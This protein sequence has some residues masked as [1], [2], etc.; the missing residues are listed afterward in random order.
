MAIVTMVSHFRFKM[1]LDLTTQERKSEARRQLCPRPPAAAEAICVPALFVPE[2]RPQA[3]IIRV[4]AVEPA[5]PSQL[6]RRERDRGDHDERA[7]AAADH[8]KDRAE[9]RRDASRFETPELVRCADE[10]SVD[11]RNPATHL[12]G[13][14]DRRQ[15]MANDDADVIERAG[16]EQH[17]QRKPEI[18]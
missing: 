12:V 1:G 4:S 14:K 17:R 13:G 6:R 10:H 3:S 9:Q 15:R 18:S 7:H 16:Q 5:E 11:R 8:R 2:N